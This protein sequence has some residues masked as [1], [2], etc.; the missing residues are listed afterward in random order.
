MFGAC[1]VAFCRASALKRTS[2][3]SIRHCPV[4]S[5]E[6]KRR[7]TRQRRGQS[8]TL[9]QRRNDFFFFFCCFFFTLLK[10]K[11]NCVQNILEIKT[12]GMEK[13]T[14]QR[15]QT[16]E[17]GLGSW[18]SA[19]VTSSRNKKAKGPRLKCT[20][21]RGRGGER[22]V[23]FLILLFVTPLKMYMGITSKLVDRKHPLAIFWGVRYIVR[24]KCTRD[25]WT[26]LSP[27]YIV[28]PTTET[29]FVTCRFYTFFFTFILFFLVTKTSVGKGFYLHNIH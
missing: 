23:Y 22:G 7:D 8:R 12:P 26:P 27:M 18:T 16:N 20:C 14:K 17:T 3:S 25:I 13:K 11:E 9:N 4:F 24:Y 1:S 6:L 2:Q 21:D 15:K 5:T 19:V 29:I 28:Q 10:H